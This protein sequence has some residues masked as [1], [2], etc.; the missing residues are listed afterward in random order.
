MP[1]QLFLTLN[2]PIR[3]HP[4]RPDTSYRVKRNRYPELHGVS[5]G[6]MKEEP[7]MQNIRSRNYRRPELAAMP[8]GV[9]S[10]GQ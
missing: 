1:A 8:A 2:E 10:H 3:K 6:Q 5:I 7:Q 9:S 4:K